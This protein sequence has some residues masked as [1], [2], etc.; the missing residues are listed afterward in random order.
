M[1]SAPSPC[2]LAFDTA[3]PCSSVA[4]VKGSGRKGR[5]IA[6]LNLVGSVSH[7]RRLLGL[8]DYLLE[9]AAVSW[10]EIDGLGVS[11]GPGSFTGLRIGMATAKGLAM[12]SGKPL[13]GIST[14]DCLAASCVTR[15]LICAALDARKK[16]VYMALYRWQEGGCQRLGKYRVVSPQACAAMITEPVVMVGEGAAL[17]HD[18]FAELLGDACQLAPA[19]LHQASAASL[20]LLAAQQYLHGTVLEDTAGPIYVRRSDAELNLLAKRAARQGNQS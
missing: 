17:Y 6:S 14:L 3:T 11:L 9:T 16:E 10:E 12:A 13:F 20:G 8:L 5:I 19:Q 18:V 4:L 2:I 1:S 7:S 15:R